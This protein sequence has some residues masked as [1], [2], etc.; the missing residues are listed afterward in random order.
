MQV[1][2]QKT[3]PLP[4]L[5]PLGRLALLLD[6]DGTLLDLAPTPSEVVVPPCLT[7]L[8][9]RLA[10]KLGGALALISGRRIEEVDALF[11]GLGIAVAGEHGAALRRA[12]D[13][14]VERPNLPAVP[15]SWREAARRLAVANPGVLLEEKPLGFVLHFRRAEGA[16]PG[17]GAALDELVGRTGAGFVVAPAI[18]A[19][20]VRP[21]AAD[22]GAAVRA[23]FERLPYAG[24][25]PLFIGDDTTDD[26]ANR[27]AR[28]LGGFGFEVASTFGSPAGVRHWLRSIIEPG[29]YQSASAPCAGW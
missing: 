4:A 14:V 23:L 7:D 16:G 15:A 27:A 8:L 5:P 9:R 12:P 29:G 20:E 2:P 24:R 28:E 17:L 22:K 21:A 26:D 1:I 19:W 10:G 6:I 3:V 13:R 25:V 18:M 11:P